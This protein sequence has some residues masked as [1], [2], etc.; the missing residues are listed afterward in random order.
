MTQTAKQRLDGLPVLY[1]FRRCPYAMR[2]RLALSSK[3]IKVE[4]REVLL[5][6]KP[7]HMRDLSAKATVPVLWQTDGAVIDES[8][9]VML[10]AW[11]QG[12]GQCAPQDDPN[13]DLVA[14][15]DG[16]F[17]HHLDRYKYA[18]RHDPDKEREHRAAA[19]DIIKTIGTRLWDNWLGGAQP[20]FVDLAILPFIRQY[21]IADIQWFDACEDIGS[22]QAWLQ[23][24]L[25]WPGFAAVMQKYPQWQDGKQ[26]V[27]FG[28]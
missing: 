4:L 15:I 24:F 22:I 23:R 20:G 3:R 12:T 17:K 21:R 16:D 10:W 13:Y 6:D 27:L 2:A 8:L 19:L 11:E 5:R 25:E 14:L 1:S 9:D 18:A 7:Q 26:G 28:A